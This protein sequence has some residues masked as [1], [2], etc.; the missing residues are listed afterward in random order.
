MRVKSPA[1]TRLKY[2]IREVLS[3]RPEFTLTKSEEGFVCGLTVWSKKREP[4]SS[5]RLSEVQ[6]E[7]PAFRATRFQREDI[8]QV[9]L[10]NLIAELLRWI[11]EPI[12]LDELVNLTAVLL[13]IKDRP[14]ESIDDETKA[15][16]EARLADTTLMT[17]PGIDSEKLLR[18]LWQAVLA[19]P[20]NQRDAFCLRFEDNHGEDLFTL[21]FEANI[22]TPTLLAQQLGRSPKDLMRMWSAMPMDYAAIATELK[23]TVPQVRKSRFDA[24]RR[25]EK[26]EDL[27]SFLARK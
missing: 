2:S 7:L 25:L 18:C 8:R 15:Y 27:R 4:I 9:P 24:L 19:L 17:D 10:T 12:E 5:R 3:R 22:A 21:L 16:V 14:A 23:A 11:D 26:E 13:D 20:K 6:L 1:R